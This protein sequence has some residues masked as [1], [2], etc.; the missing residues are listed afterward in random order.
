MNENVLL[1]ERGGD[2]AAVFFAARGGGTEF[3]FYRIAHQLSATALLVKDPA[4]NWYNA[5][6][7][8][9]GAT[10]DEIACSLR[11]T[12]GDRRIVTF[13]SSMGGYAA[14]LFGC[15]LGAERCVALA[16]QTRLD[17]KL[18]LSPA[19][20]VQLQAP[21]LQRYLLESPSTN[22]RIFI[23]GSDLVDAYHAYR[24]ADR[25]NV[26][27][28]VLPDAGH[29]VAETLAGT[30]VLREIVATTVAGIS[31]APTGFEAGIEDV[32]LRQ[33]IEDAVERHYFGGDP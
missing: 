16:P 33:A 1:L 5:G 8:G 27:V 23:G 15:L 3:G 2:V 6:I 20:D 25:Q 22:V 32:V 4:N 7:D 13:G 19:A 10:V 9:V 18:P 31:Q 24:V 17:S 21:D 30:D 28:L 11:A 29:S 14:I 12:L 26:E